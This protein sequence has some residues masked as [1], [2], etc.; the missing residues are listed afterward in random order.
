MFTCQYTCVLTARV[1]SSASTSCFMKNSNSEISS[2]E[3]VFT[4]DTKITCNIHVWGLWGSQ[5][6]MQ[7]VAG[8]LYSLLNGLVCISP[9]ANDC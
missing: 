5:L 8:A 4:Q 7:G 2:V 9:C 6:G 1:G 3:Y